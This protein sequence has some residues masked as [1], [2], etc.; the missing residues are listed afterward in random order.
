MKGGLVKRD[1]EERYVEQSQS[2][3]REK[4]DV[5]NVTVPSH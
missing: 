4:E 1:K 3:R 5:I 2:A